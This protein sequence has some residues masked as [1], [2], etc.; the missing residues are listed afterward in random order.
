MGSLVEDYL[1][2]VHSA[3][4]DDRGGAVADN[5]PEMGEVDHDAFGICIATGDGHLYEVG[6]TRTEFTIQ[7]IA[8]PFT[9]GLALADRGHATVAGKIDVEPSGD[10][11]NEISLDPVTA[12]RVGF[13]S[14]TTS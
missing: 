13:S 8:K 2:A 6:D 10:A 14:S 5:I 9:Y 4:L 7:S 12:Q 11:F 3:H 1:A